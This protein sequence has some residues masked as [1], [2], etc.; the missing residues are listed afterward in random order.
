MSRNGV[1]TAPDRVDIGGIL[2][3]R[4][5][6]SLSF[7]KGILGSH[8]DMTT[9]YFLGW[10]TEH[11]NQGAWLIPLAERVAHGIRH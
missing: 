2:S 1:D 4:E 10:S 3:A 5:S 6:N 7:E 11:V 8:G 9:L